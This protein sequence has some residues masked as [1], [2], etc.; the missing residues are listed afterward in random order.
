MIT[1][2]AITQLACLAATVTLNSKLSSKYIICNCNRFGIS[3][4][5]FPNGEKLCVGW[6][7]KYS[8]STAMIYST[9]IL[10]AVVSMAIKWVLRSK[11]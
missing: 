4:I 9:S 10:I 6:L 7:S 3:N 5:V 1:N 11:T 8:L 2:L